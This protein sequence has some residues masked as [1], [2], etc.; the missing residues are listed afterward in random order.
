MS[1]KIDEN[2]IEITPKTRAKVTP[3]PKSGTPSEGGS[4]ANTIGNGENAK[5]SFIWI[6]IRWSFVIGGITSLAIYMHPTYCQTEL[7]GNLIE[8]MKAAWSI[9]I[10]IITLALGYSFGKGK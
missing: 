1:V 5:N 4:I 6:S 2:N 9:F 3:K 7:Q 10:P 8:D